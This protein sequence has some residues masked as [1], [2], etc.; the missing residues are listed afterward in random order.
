M[1]TIYP[2]LAFALIAVVA[3]GV[4]Y[5]KKFN[6]VVVNG[7]LTGEVTTPPT[8]DTPPPVPLSSD[9]VEVYTGIKVERTT[10]TLNLA[11]KG[12]T[13]SLKGEVRLL[14]NLTTLD[15]SNNKFTGLPAEIGQLHN[16]E[17]LN[18]SGNPLT[19]LPQ[20][21]GKLSKLK[22]LDL[23]GTTYST[24][25]LAIVKKGLP[26]SVVILTDNK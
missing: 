15:I 13:G 17:T 9:T 1:K 6:N 23:R 24:A 12:L 21:L 18:L 2:I 14:L 8:T 26:T 4:W 11:G 20:E 3:G 19:G 22:T 25:D 5:S 7:T 10:A 16:L